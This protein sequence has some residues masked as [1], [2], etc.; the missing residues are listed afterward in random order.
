MRRSVLAITVLLVAACNRQTIDT[1]A[2][3]SASPTLTEAPETTSSSTQQPGAA[4]VLRDGRHFVYI[5]SVAYERR[6]VTFDLAEFYTGDAAR[7]AGAEDGET[8]EG[9]YYIRN[10]NPRLRTLPLASAVQIKIVDWPD[11]CDSIN[12]DLDKFAIAFEGANDD[13]YH[14]PSSSYWLTVRNG[15]VDLIEE[16]YLP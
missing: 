6:T 7:R 16:Q 8:V 5:K 9:D 10:H 11:C 15:A 3:E 12:G 14:G 2:T 13:L 1:A 4:P